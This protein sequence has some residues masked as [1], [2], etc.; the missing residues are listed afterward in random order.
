MSNIISLNKFFG[1]KK[2]YSKITEMALR[3]MIKENKVIVEENEDVID[4]FE[5]ILTCHKIANL[6]DNFRGNTN[7]SKRI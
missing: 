4:P 3:C 1:N 5:F 6:Y 2:E 7:A